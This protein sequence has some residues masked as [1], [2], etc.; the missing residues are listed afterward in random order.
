M[1]AR[2]LSLMRCEAPRDC[3]EC[4]GCTRDSAEYEAKLDKV[5]IVVESHITRTFG[6]M[7]DVSELDFRD[8][9]ENT[10]ARII[11]DLEN[12]GWLNLDNVDAAS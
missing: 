3:G 8:D 2:R 5:Q 11:N 10:A 7:F 1:Q 12:S 4:D 9:V 6:E